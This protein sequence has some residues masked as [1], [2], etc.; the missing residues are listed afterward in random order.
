M[1]TIYLLVAA[2]NLAAQV[3]PPPAGVA[4]DAAGRVRP[5]LGIAGAF[6][7]GERMAEN[8]ISAASSGAWTVVKTADRVLRIEGPGGEPGGFDAP[9]GPA[10]FAFDPSGKPVR[11]WFPDTREM[12]N[13]DSG[14]RETLD[15]PGALALAVRATGELEALVFRDGSLWL[16]T[17]RDGVFAGAPEPLAA[18][19]FESAPPAIL[20]GTGVAAWFDGTSLIVRASNGDERRARPEFAVRSIEQMSADWLL[21]RGPDGEPPVA[22]RLDTADIQL[23]RIPEEPR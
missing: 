18:G 8:A 6:T 13:L 21:L 9:G 15:I 11:A 22:A 17:I 19:P 20:P 10:L 4:R 2:A 3:A 14:A 5:V 7:L 1:R 16:D 23:S 12:L